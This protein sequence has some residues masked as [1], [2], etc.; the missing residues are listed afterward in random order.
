MASINT[1]FTRFIIK[2]NYSW[3]NDDIWVVN[4]KVLNPTKNEIAFFYIV[5]FI[6]FFM[7][8]GLEIKNILKTRS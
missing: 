4:W 8:L 7:C 3:N 6:E 5:K 1:K 2:I